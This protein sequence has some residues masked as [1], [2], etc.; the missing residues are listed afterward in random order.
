ML[1]TA[2]FVHYVCADTI[3]EVVIFCKSLPQHAKAT[4]V[5]E[6]LNNFFANQNFEWNK[7]N[8]SLCTDGA[9]AM[10]G[11]T[12]GFATLVQKKA[13]QVSVTHC[14]LHRYALALK[15]LPENLRNL[16]SDSVTIINLIRARA[17]NHRIFKKLCQEKGEKH[18]VLLYHT[19]VCWLSSGQ[20]L[21]H[22]FEL[23]NKISLFF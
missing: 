11:K 18:E 9:P 20:V 2:S 5:L 10:L 1:S 12:F 8:G 14:F 17:L 4:D 23:R 22:L 15:T 21:K 19:E 7:K 3:K 13:T 6:M 16:W